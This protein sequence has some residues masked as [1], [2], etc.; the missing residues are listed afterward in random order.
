M[1]GDKEFAITIYLRA[2]Q[3]GSVLLTGYKGS[4]SYPT[5]KL[6]MVYHKTVSTSPHLMLM[7]YSIWE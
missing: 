2:T 1:I 5:R 7:Y 6:V 3:E 4:E